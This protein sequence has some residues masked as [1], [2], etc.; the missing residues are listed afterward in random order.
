MRLKHTKITKKSLKKYIWIVIW[1]APFVS[2]LLGYLAI[3]KLFQPKTF[4]TPAIVGKKLQQAI[5]ILSDRKLNIRFLANKEEPDLPNNT[6]LSQKPIAGREIKPNQAVYV[7]VSKK[8]HKVPCPHLINKHK[9]KIAKQLNPKN[10]RN[11][12][13][14]L[15]SNYPTDHCIAQHPTS[16]TPLKKNN[17]ITYL[18]QGNQKPVVFPNFKGKNLE[19]VLDFLKPYT[20]IAIKIVTPYNNQNSKNTNP[21][22]QDLVISDQR[23]LAGS[24]VHLHNTNKLL[25][26]LQTDK[27][28]DT[29]NQ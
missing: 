13:Y 16:N 26:H 4:S 25:V 3:G 12:S 28:L 18:S 14:Y 9:D 8:P 23:P 10:I 24:I 6:I 1:A 29:I 20:N 22:A 17:V 11:R 27:I 7:V 2:F 5:S 15:P 19:K 21:S